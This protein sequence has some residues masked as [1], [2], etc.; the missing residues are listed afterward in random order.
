MR[1]AVGV[2]ELKNHASAVLRRVRDGEA[3]TVTDRGRP[4]ALLVPVVAGESS[5][6]ARLR[7]LVRAGRL[8]WSG[9]K[10][11]GLERPPR[12]RG[13]SVASAVAEDRR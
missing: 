11:R 3:I 6:D 12:A 5:H 8:S 13:R 10:P 1:S 7:A 4:V 9:G 2:R